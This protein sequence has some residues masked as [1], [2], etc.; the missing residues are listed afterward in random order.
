MAKVAIKSKVIIYIIVALVAIVAALALINRPSGDLSPASLTFSQGGKVLHTFTL[1]EIKDMPG[2]SVEKSINSSKH[3]DESGVFT[4]VPLHNLI[5]AV[6][7]NLLTGERNFITRAE[8][9]F[10][11]VFATHE[12][13]EPDNILVVYA[14]DGKSL[15]SYEEGG[16]GPLRIIIQGDAF[17]N[18]STKYLKEIEV[19]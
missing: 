7:A 2:I 1:E 10:A 4:G 19:K 11:S 6:D 13:I 15:G 14:K 5:N 3:D 18:R 12:V 16:T 8:D 9:G 17:A